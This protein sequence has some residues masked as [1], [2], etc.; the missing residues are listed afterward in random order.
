M[1]APSFVPSTLA[2]QPRKG[3]RLPPAE[4]WMADR[5]A[6]LGPVQPAGPSLG[7][8][9]PDQGFALRLARRFE[10]RLVLS[11]DEH[12]HDVV[13]GCLGVALKR[14]ALFGRAPVI[15][16]LTVAFAVWGFLDQAPG[17]L[18][19]LRRP[20]FQA[21]GHDY[22]RQRAIADAVPPETL[23]LS[24][25]EVQRRFPADWRALLGLAGDGS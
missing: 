3:L 10:G 5:P 8:Q 15:H 4:T 6:D 12:E 1:A 24:H 7:T 23:R 13:A 11:T 18:V 9:G 2:Q 22:T 16:D 20:M 21:V 14:A 19:A 25:T 17:E